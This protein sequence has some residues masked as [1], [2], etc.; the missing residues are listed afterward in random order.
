MGKLAHQSPNS[1][2][3]SAYDFRH[4]WI[5]FDHVSPRS[6]RSRL[7]AAWSPSNYG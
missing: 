2:R 1:R 4:S 6:I 5:I 3:I 7:P